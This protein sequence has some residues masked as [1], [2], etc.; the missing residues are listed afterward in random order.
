MSYG[1]DNPPPAARPAAVAPP[2]AAPAASPN[3]SVRLTVRAAC[4]G[5]TAAPPPMTPELAPWLPATATLPAA[6]DTAADTMALPVTPIALFAI[7][8]RAEGL[9]P[10]VSRPG[11]KPVGD[12]VTRVGGPTFTAVPAAGARCM[13]GGTGAAAAATAA[14]CATEPTTALAAVVGIVKPMRPASEP[15]AAAVEADEDEP[16]A[17]GAT[18]VPAP[19]AGPPTA[20]GLK[21]VRCAA[22][23]AASDPGPTAPKW[24]P[25]RGALWARAAR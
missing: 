11:G 1:E 24:A 5:V 25:E 19:A 16:A 13:V 17:L 21:R 23:A 15:S 2:G 8:L 20:T 12:L 3:A 9:R 7:R 4:C 10:P 22:G 14:G 6:A 18:A